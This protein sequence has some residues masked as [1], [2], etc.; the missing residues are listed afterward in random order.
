MTYRIGQTIPY[1]PG[2]GIE[3]ASLP[4]PVWHCF[5]TPPRKEAAAIAWLD[6][7]GVHGWRP[8]ETRWRRITRGKRRKVEYLAS[9]VLRYVFARFSGKPQWDVLRGCRW[10]TGIVGV[11]GRPACITDDALSKMAAVPETLAALREARRAAREITA[12]CKATIIDGA[13]AGW[14]VDIARV[15]DGMAAFLV[16]LLGADE[17][18]VPVDRLMK[19]AAA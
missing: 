12:G 2:R 3:G 19:V 18:L 7:R 1:E 5:W 9:V 4:V 13:M 17:A 8:V 16:P 15:S 11:G 6:L 14:V 10:I